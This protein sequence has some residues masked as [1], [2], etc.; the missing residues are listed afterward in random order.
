MAAAAFAIPA[1]LA[2]NAHAFT[3]FG[4]T[5]W[6][7]K[8]DA[9]AEVIDPVR[10]TLAIDTD[11]A[12]ADLAKTLTDSSLLERDK[13]QPV[14]GDLGLVIRARDDRDRLVAA[15]YENARYGGVVTV[16]VGGRLLEDLPPNPTFPRGNPVPVEIR[17]DP[18]PR[19]TLGKVT[20]AQDAAGLDPSKYGL[21]TGG[22]AGSLTILKAGDRIVSDL[23]AE[24]RPLAKLGAR[25]VVA[26]HE[27][28]TVDVTISA[29][30]GPI[31]PLGTVSVKGSR[32]VNADFISRYSRLRPGQTYS[33]TEIAKASERLRKLGVFAS[34]T[35]RE[36]QT[37]APD[38]S[39]PLTIEVAEGKT[40]FFGVGA[41]V[42]SIDGL[43]LQ[44]YWG[45]R[46]LFG[47]AETLRIDGSIG[48]V[49]ET[50]DVGKL[51]YSAG[52]SFT[53]PGAFFPA[54]TLNASIKAATQDTTSYDLTSISGKIG[55]S[56][57]LTDQDTVAGAVSLD[58]TDVEDA[59]GENRYLTF[60]VPL[61]YTRDTRDKPL[62]ATTGYKLTANATP[63]YEIFGS[64]PFISFEGS[65]SG[66]WGLG[67]E[68]RVVL[69]GKIAAGTLLDTGGLE[70]L[71]AN[72]RFF[73]GGGG[74]VRGYAFQ[75]ISPRNEAGDATGGRAYATASVEARV[76]ITDSIGLVPFVDAGSVTTANIPDFT[77]IR[78]GAG[79]GL[80]YATPFGPIRLDFA[81]PLDR[82][83]D[84][85][86][87][88][89]YAGIGQS[90]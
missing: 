62:D 9:A 82:Y 66:Y 3:I 11:G 7:E 32:Q 36:G 86:D 42:S 8:P 68:D 47:N 84:G 54:A 34:V 10:F 59:F 70:D 21:T 74:S 55:L 18:G 83:P 24:G 20:L 79:I 5:L 15:L 45:H 77:D 46:N 76:K 1:V 63:S 6:G 71:P 28:N 73:A 61:D 30:G 23:K 87:Y 85:S 26:N 80:R 49:L 78:A 19:F 37:L 75:E 64:T 89:I 39:L 43:G 12:D 52:V 25:E 44:G 33:P 13:D 35:I 40:R 31:A 57:E 14:S 50:T 69:A 41:S 81:V 16:K 27:T 2:E 67:A 72:R 56:Y 65:A 60:A 4:I 29:E 48:R 58:W 17:V 38:G 51:D 88:G 22:D 90:F 53:K